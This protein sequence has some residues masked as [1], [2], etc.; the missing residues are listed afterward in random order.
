MNGPHASPPPQE[1]GYEVEVAG[2]AEAVELARLEV[3]KCLDEAMGFHTGYL[4]LEPGYPNMF[5]NILADRRRRILHAIMRRTATNIYFP[6]PFVVQSAEPSGREASIVITGVKK[7]N[8]EDAKRLLED[9]AESKG[10]TVMQHTIS[11]PAHKLDW[12]LANRRDAITK[13]M[14]DNGTF[15]LFPV[16]S[17]SSGSE[18]PSL[19]SH[20]A[21]R[22]QTRNVTIYGNDRVFIERTVRMLTLV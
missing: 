21:Q 16:A 13:I 14:W 1:D 2:N 5:H 6:S 9:I 8:V 3:L 15:A 12:M 20:Q 17:T 7:E 4:N 18:S 19:N 22:L 11:M 10:P